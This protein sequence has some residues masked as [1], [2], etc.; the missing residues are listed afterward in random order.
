MMPYCAEHGDERRVGVQG[1]RDDQP[2]QDELQDVWDDQRVQDELQDVWDDQ[3][4]LEADDPPA[5]PRV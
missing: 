1:E 5:V 4:V 3:R 2:G